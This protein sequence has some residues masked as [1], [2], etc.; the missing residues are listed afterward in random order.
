MPGRDHRNRGERALK[1]R[2]LSSLRAYALLATGERN[3]LI[4]AAFFLLEVAV[5]VVEEGI[6]RST[7]ARAAIAQ[8]KSSTTGHGGKSSLGLKGRSV[9]RARNKLLRMGARAKNRCYGLPPTVQ[10]LQRVGEFNMSGP[11]PGPR[12]TGRSEG[13]QAQGAQRTSSVRGSPTDSLNSDSLRLGALRNPLYCEFLRSSGAAIPPSI[14]C[15]PWQAT[16]I[17]P[18]YATNARSQRMPT[19]PGG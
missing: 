9:G 6:R 16:P 7:G 19:I 4:E 10:L 8:A 18:R 5:R 3:L 12:A 14:L 1:P 15:S 11:N 13:A 2:E 17:L